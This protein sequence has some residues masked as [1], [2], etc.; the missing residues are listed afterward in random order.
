MHLQDK[1]HPV[2]HRLSLRSGAYEQMET[3]ARVRAIQD[4]IA[5]ELTHAHRT[6]MYTGPVPE[7][8]SF[9][10]MVC[11]NYRVL[12]RRIAELEADRD[13]LLD[14][15]ERLQLAAKAAGK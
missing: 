11:E 10:E 4:G 3:L 9:A 1:A 13:E 12:L 15:D 7:G 6:P 5:S 14:Q 8:R 2:W